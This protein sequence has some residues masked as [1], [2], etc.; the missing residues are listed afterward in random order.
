MWFKA[1]KG[2]T[3]S[4]VVHTAYL[5]FHYTFWENMYTHNIDLITKST[6]CFAHVASVWCATHEKGPYTICGQRKSISVIATV[7]SDLSILYPSTYTTVPMDSVSG[8]RRPWSVCAYA[9][10]DLDLRCLQ[11]AF[12]SLRSICF[13]NSLHV[14]VASGYDMHKLTFFL[15]FF[16]LSLH[17]VLFDHE[18]Q[19]GLFLG[20]GIIFNLCNGYKGVGWGG[21]CSQ[22]L[23]PRDNALYKYQPCQWFWRNI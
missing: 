17:W 2:P 9:Q 22:R 3:P 18:A 20:N 11:I 8:Q 1:V 23:Y 16:V 15:S 12:R 6:E 5:C 13:V 21:G 4:N 10:A 7:Q 19:W 14:H